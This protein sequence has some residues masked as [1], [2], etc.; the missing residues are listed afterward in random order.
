MVWYVLHT[1]EPQTWSLCPQYS[2]SATA[3]VEIE[4]LG[5]RFR[6]NCEGEEVLYSLIFVTSYYISYWTAKCFQ[7]KN[8]ET[9][10]CLLGTDCM[11][12]DCGLNRSETHKPYPS[13]KFDI[14]AWF[15]LHKLGTL[16]EKAKTKKLFFLDYIHLLDLNSDVFR[17]KWTCVA[18]RL[19]GLHWNCETHDKFMRV[20]R[21]AIGY[22]QKLAY[23]VL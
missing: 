16:H 13:Q 17:A 4:V 8:L 11:L 21:P 19:S 14:S 20:G 6:C 18:V 23:F 3:G 12:G 2:C 7:F 9:V 5:L 10:M 22:I 1:C 15:C